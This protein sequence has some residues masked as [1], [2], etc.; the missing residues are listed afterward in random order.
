MLERNLGVVRQLTCIW[1]LSLIARDWCQALRHMTQ[2]CTCVEAWSMWVPWLVP[3]LSSTTSHVKAFYILSSPAKLCFSLQSPACVEGLAELKNV[4]SAGRVEEC[5]EGLAELKNVLR[6]GQRWRMYWG[7]G[8]GEEC[9]GGWA[10]LK[11]VF[12]GPGSYP[13]D[14]Q[15]YQ[16][17]SYGL[18]TLVLFFIRV[19]KC[20]RA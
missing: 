9:V 20:L 7:L 10:M 18:R 3:S 6:A 1:W 4:L 14:T 12:R 2:G 17:K 19:R 16:H 15:I 11:D 13:T 5:V 8:R